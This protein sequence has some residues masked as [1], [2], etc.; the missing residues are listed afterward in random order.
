[1]YLVHVGAL[2]KKKSVSL[3]EELRKGG[4]NVVSNLG[5]SSL[6]AQLEGANKANAPMALILGQKEV[7]E[8]SIIIRDMKAGTQETVPL[9][10]IVGEIKKKL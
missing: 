7:F 1:M 3:L 8:E 6:S 10:K 2:A 9:D 5:K 4:V